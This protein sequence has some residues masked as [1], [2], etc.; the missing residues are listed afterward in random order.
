MSG[1]NNLKIGSVTCLLVFIAFNG[2]L[3]LGRLILKFSLLN[4]STTSLDETNM[5]TDLE[6]SEPPFLSELNDNSSEIFHAPRENIIS[7][8]S[9]GDAENDL[10]DIQLGD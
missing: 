8:N 2:I 7:S 9:K 10:L 3:F 1:N 4:D 6:S 5:F